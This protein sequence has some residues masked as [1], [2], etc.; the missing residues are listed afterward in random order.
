MPQTATTTDTSEA[1]ARALDARDP[2]RSFREKLAIPD[3]GAIAAAVGAGTAPTGGETVYLTGNSLGAMPR[4]VPRL[5]QQ[6]LEDWARLGVEGHLHGRDPWLPYHEQF[7]APLARLCGALERE[8]VAM[9]S[10][11][12]NLHLLMASF[13]RPTR[14]R[15]KIVI[16]DTAFPS[17]S[18]A[19]ASQAAWHAR[20]AGFDASRA[21]VRLAPREGEGT[22]RTEDIVAAIEREGP[23]IALVMLGAVNYLTGQWFDMEAVTRA[24][25]DA[26]AIVGWDLAHAMGNVPMRLHDIGADFAA[27]CSYKYLNAGPGAVAGAFVHERHLSE[28]VPQFA[29]WWGNDPATRFRMGPEFSPVAR[30]D[31]WALSNPP[32]FSLTPLKASLALFDEARI[33]RLREKSL[34]LTGYMET[35]LRSMA[36]SVR[37]LTP[38][39]A[40]RRGCQLSLVLPGDA[41]AAHAALLRRGIVTDFREPH[42]IRAAPV[43]LYNSFHDV[44]R[45]VSALRKVSAS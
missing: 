13:Y 6:E 8:V 45:F 31:R 35:L 5:V 2:L 32:I 24:G 20:H 22:L 34:A 19:V 36:P 17:D 12:V 15:F 18:Y 26:G 4:D 23:S 21:I 33:D 30:A 40:A 43:P 16:E 10:L 39:E 37:V 1:Y 41:R 14:E 29:G 9:N 25:H 38:A 3:A 11:T 42:V 44:Y 28:P 7:R 27:W